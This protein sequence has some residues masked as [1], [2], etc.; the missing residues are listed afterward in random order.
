MRTSLKNGQLPLQKQRV[1]FTYRKEKEG[2]R[3]AAIIA[4]LSLF[5]I[6]RD[7]PGNFTSFYFFLSFYSICKIQLYELYRN[8]GSKHSVV[9]VLAEHYKNTFLKECSE[10]E[11]SNFDFDKA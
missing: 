4:F 1:C 10:Y 11:N 3:A 6:K 5:S 9:F 2:K 7:S 8:S